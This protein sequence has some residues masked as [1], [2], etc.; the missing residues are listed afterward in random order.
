M[1]PG[2]SSA[3]P[4]LVTR[5]VTS[6]PQASVSSATA[7]RTAASLTQNRFRSVN[8]PPARRLGPPGGLAGSTLPSG[9]LPPSR[10]RPG[11]RGACR[12][13]RPRPCAPGRA[14]CPRP[15]GAPYPGPATHPC[16][17]PR[18]SGHASGRCAL[19]RQTDA[20]GER[21][22]AVAGQPGGTGRAPTHRL[23][24]G[25]HLH[26]HGCGSGGRCWLTGG[27]TGSVDRDRISR[28]FRGALPR[29]SALRLAHARAPRTPRPA[30]APHTA[31]TSPEPPAAGPWG[32]GRGVRKPGSPEA[33]GCCLS[34]GPGCSLPFLSPCYQ[35][36]GIANPVSAYE[37]R[38]SELGIGQLLAGDY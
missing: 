11:P 36:A 12:P 35:R 7:G 1:V 28:R 27:A 25:L 20:R 24:D 2:Q 21:M 4:E 6:P 13:P 34:E 9:A 32:R 19:R 5:Q 16:S 29:P 31:R 22:R 26:S 17:A 38:E 10:P 15:R 14:G 8:S 33:S 37:K 30:C 23:R 18:R 3:H